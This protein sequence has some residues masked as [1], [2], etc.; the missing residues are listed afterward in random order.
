[1]NYSLQH[2]LTLPITILTLLILFIILHLYVKLHIMTLFHI[3]PRL[4]R[5]LLGLLPR[6]ITHHMITHAKAGIF[7]PK[8]FNLL[9]S[10]ISTTPTIIKQLF[11]ILL[12][13][14]QCKWSMMLLLQIILGPSLTFL[15]VQPLL[16]VNGSLKTNSM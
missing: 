1:M 3:L 10:P 11:L 8:F 5:I 2:T 15:P 9:A 16:V 4:K 7:K 6:L 14:V 12:G 13:L